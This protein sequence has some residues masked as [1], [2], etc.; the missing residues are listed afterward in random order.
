MEPVKLRDSKAFL[1]I[2]IFGIL[3]FAFCLMLSTIS[4]LRKQDME[5]LLICIPV[6]GGFTLLCALMLPY[7]CRRKLL[8]YDKYVSYTPAY[9]KIRTFS[10]SEIGYILPKNEKF[11]IYSYDGRKLAVFENNM[12]AFPAACDY[13]MERNVRFAPPTPLRPVSPMKKKAQEW[14]QSLNLTDMDSYIASHW[15]PQTIQKQKKITRI[16]R[17]LLVIL[18]LLSVLLSGKRRL[19]ACMLILL[20]NYALCLVLYPKI[21]ME[22]GKKCDERHITAPFWSNAVSMLLLVDFLQ[23]INMEEGWWLPMS[24]VLT[25]ILLLPCLLMLWR[26][27]IKEHPLKLLFMAVTLFVFSLISAPALSYVTAGAPTHDTVQV[28]E[29]ESHRNTNTTYYSVMVIW[30]GELQKMN[31][32]GRLYRSVKEGDN[33]RVCV[34]E[35]I[36][37]Q[38]LWRIHR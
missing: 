3:F 16:L 6:F 17:I 34:R 26:R 36:F 5:T 9:G 1:I 18:S 4:G 29:K 13:L 31:V 30:R 21:T 37:G 7:F 38:E 33:V 22:S 15:S 25:V 10:Y 27:K 24:I 28:L 19:T 12:P 35:S 11:I 32:S 23:L 8:L 20:F 2:D 14:N